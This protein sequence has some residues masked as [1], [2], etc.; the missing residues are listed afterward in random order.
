S[1]KRLGIALPEGEDPKGTSE[2]SKNAQASAEIG[3]MLSSESRTSPSVE[4]ELASQ[5]P[6][7][8]RLRLSSTSGRRDEAGSSSRSLQSRWV[9]HRCSDEFLAYINSSI[10]RETAV[11]GETAS[12]LGS[13]ERRMN[14]ARM[15]H[16]C[17]NLIGSVHDAPLY[18]RAWEIFAKS[19]SHLHPHLSSSEA[20]SP[21]AFRA[22]ASVRAMCAA[23]VSLAVDVRCPLDSPPSSWIVTWGHFFSG[24]VN[25]GDSNINLK[26]FLVKNEEDCRKGSERSK[27]LMRLKVVLSSSIFDWNLDGTATVADCLRICYDRFILA[28]PELAPNSFTWFNAGAVLRSCQSL[29]IVA[30]LALTGSDAP[31]EGDEEDSHACAA[32]HVALAILALVTSYSSTTLIDSSA[33]PMMSAVPDLSGVSS[34]L[35]KGVPLLDAYLTSCDEEKVAVVGALATAAGCFVSDL[36]RMVRTVWS[37]SNVKL[38]FMTV[39][40]LAEEQLLSGRAGNTGRCILPDI[41]KSHEEFHWLVYPRK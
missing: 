1:V 40:A 20:T 31:S 32:N 3:S 23:S 10:T 19:V 7:A 15:L 38:T 21:E 41:Q 25:Y 30:S 11:C 9:E 35:T 12:I 4:M 5:P 28:L 17:L 27:A 26:S 18:C 2:S 34:L 8:K 33:R 37:A 14:L 29:S 39:D 13:P 36:I 22:E 24:F 16:R 6:A